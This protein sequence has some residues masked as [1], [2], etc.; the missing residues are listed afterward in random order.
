[1]RRLVAGE[2]KADLLAAQFMRSFE[3]DFQGVTPG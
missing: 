3:L 1:M 2:E